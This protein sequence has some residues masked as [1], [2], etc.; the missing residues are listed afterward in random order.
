MV[1]LF[2]VEALNSWEHV[3][4]DLFGPGLR[5]MEEKLGKKEA[6]R[7]LA[8]IIVGTLLGAFILNRVDEELY[9]GTPAQFDV[10]GLLTG[11]LASGNG[12]STNEQLGVWVDD[13]WQKLTGERLF[14][15]DEDA[16]NGKFNLAA[17]AEDTIYNISN[18]IPYAR[19]VAGVFGVGDQT[20]PM[21]D[22][23][24][25]AT[26]IGKTLKK[27]AAGK[28]DSPGDF[29][30]EVGRQLMGLVGDTV[31]GGRQLEKFA[32]GGEAILR[33]GSYQG[34]GDNKRLQYPVEPLLED[35]FEALRAAL[36]GK[37]ALNESRV[38]WAEGGKALSASQT[39]TYQELVDM[40]ADRE[41]VYDAIQKWRKIDKD[42]SLTDGERE[43]AQFE[44]V[45]K[46]KLTNEQKERLHDDLS[47]SSRSYAAAQEA[48]KQGISAEAYAK[49]KDTTADLTADKDENG[50]AINGSKKAKVLDAIDKMQL[51]KKQ[52]DW[53][54]LDAG[55]SE[56]D[57]GKAPWNS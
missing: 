20:L 39:R 43:A 49:Y 5:E 22:L 10:L 54:Y 2:Q 31:P 57:I 13:V 53:L 28:F 42:D 4:Q 1:N 50:N 21:P 25:T 23:W 35:P 26:G 34:T 41:V 56:K 48:Q 12:L 11:F 32:Q 33:G 18:D 6:S 45:R 19:N 7:R 14:G 9:G 29:W 16:G 24:G 15:T 36:F 3:T 47:R 38:Y 46:L 27:Q 44:L 30:S 8:G 40:G 52:K 17:A 37:N 51:S 55:Y